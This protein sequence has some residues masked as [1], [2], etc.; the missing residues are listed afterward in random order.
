MMKYVNPSKVDTEYVVV[1]KT[2][3]ALLGEYD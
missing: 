2:M 3:N 1:V